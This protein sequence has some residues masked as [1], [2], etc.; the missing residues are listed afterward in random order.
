ML[1]PCHQDELDAEAD[2]EGEA[3]ADLIVLDAAPASPSV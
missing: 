3:D 2:A 1:S